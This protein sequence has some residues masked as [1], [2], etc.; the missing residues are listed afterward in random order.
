MF[1]RE[2]ILIRVFYPCRVGSG[3]SYGAGGVL[4]LTSAAETISSF[5]HLRGRLLH[6]AVVA[7]RSMVSLSLA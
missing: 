3:A 1:C 4:T 2:S 6:G 7:N 5:H